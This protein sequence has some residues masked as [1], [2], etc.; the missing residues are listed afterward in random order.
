MAKK[1]KLTVL[2]SVPGSWSEGRTKESTL[3]AAETIQPHV[4]RT[5][6][7]VNMVL[8]RKL[9]GNG[10]INLVVNSKGVVG[11]TPAQPITKADYDWVNKAAGIKGA[12]KTTQEIPPERTKLGQISMLTDTAKMGCYSW[13][14]PAGPAMPMQLRDPQTGRETTYRVNG[15]CPGARPAFML[16]PE[17]Q[18]EAAKLSA[19]AQAAGPVKIPDYICNGCYAL[20]GSYGNPSMVFVQE[21][22]FRIAKALMEEG[23]FV[24][25]LTSAIRLG[26]LASFHRHAELKRPDRAWEIPNPRY[27]RI[28]DAGDMYDKAYFR[29]WTDVVRNCAD[30]ISV[31]QLESHLLPELRGSAVVARRMK[32]VL[33]S[34]VTS[35]PGVQFW[36][37]TRMWV[38]PSA[39]DYAGTDSATVACLSEEDLRCVPPNLTLRPSAMHFNDVAPVLNDPAALGYQPGWQA[40][41]T[42]AQRDLL[43]QRAWWVCP[44]YAEPA[45]PGSAPPSYGQRTGIGGGASYN[46]QGKLAGGTC[47]RAWG[48]T[49]PDNTPRPPAE[50]GGAGCRAC[51]DRPDLSVVY[52]EH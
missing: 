26:Q 52:P 40:G 43:L 25:A 3:H 11:I 35:L 29:A 16:L 22:R 20:K 37:P 38:T 48:P 21:M 6:P 34:G 23:R 36:C 7:F 46:A 1:K 31:E 24:D 5:R 13:N 32:K 15:T 8:D 9:V 33:K 44:A 39:L 17:R 42:A 10:R 2:G 14:L 49:D 50:L 12:W 51:W 27:F 18:L 47:A 28:H 4:Y 19:P 30:P 45:T 41:S